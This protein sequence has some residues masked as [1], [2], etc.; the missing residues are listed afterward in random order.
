M[1]MK[2]VFKLYVYVK[3]QE[4]AFVHIGGIWYTPTVKAKFL[5]VY[6]YSCDYNCFQ[7][8]HL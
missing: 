3:C 5:S 1:N 8:Q 4:N 2:C 7:F 6:K